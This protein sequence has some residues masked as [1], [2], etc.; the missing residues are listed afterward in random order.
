MG[1]ANYNNLPD[2]FPITVGPMDQREIPSRP[3]YLRFQTEPLA[4]DLTVQG[5]IE[6]ELWAATDGPDTDFM[7]KLVDVYPDGYEALL[8]DSPIRARY[9]EGRAPGDIR[10]MTPG[11]PEL[12]IIDLWSI[13]QTFEKGHRLAVHVSS[14]N[15][16][17][18]EI[19][20]NTGEAAGSSRI[21]PRI[22][23][24]TIHHDQDRPSA[25]VLPITDLNLD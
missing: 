5:R 2:R 13:S 21:P 1:G 4:E 18:F 8:L 16:P 20:S 10:M 22:A 6:V 12:M 23:A 25:I 24:N 15:Y 7:V 3:D 19:N 17:R 11:R 9:R 14:S